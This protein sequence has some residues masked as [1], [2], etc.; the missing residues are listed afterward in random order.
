MRIAAHILT[1]VVA[2]GAAFAADPPPGTLTAQDPFA[3]LFDDPVVARG[4]GVE[5]RQSQV[6]E[7]YT[8]FKAQ[9]AIRNQV[10]LS[11]PP[12]R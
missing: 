2:V 7:A 10:A 1:I 11:N 3:S 4:K 12:S 8:A 6:E 9:M 5:V